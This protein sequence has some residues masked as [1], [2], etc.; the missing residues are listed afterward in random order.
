[1]SKLLQ[2]LDELE[3]LVEIEYNK[4]EDEKTMLLLTNKEQAENLKKMDTLLFDTMARN[5]KLININNDLLITINKY[6]YYNK[7][8]QI[9]FATYIFTTSMIYL[10]SGLLI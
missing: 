4:Q 2:E 7:L 3:N 5:T 10:F 1:M 6:K 9:I 8:G